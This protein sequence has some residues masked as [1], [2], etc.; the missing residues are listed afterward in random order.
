MKEDEAKEQEMVKWYTWVPPTRS[1][2]STQS[3][4]LN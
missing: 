2:P 3:S 4:T 1:K